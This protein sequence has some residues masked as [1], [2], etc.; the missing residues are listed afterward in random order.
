MR[1]RQERR[2]HM[3]SHMAR[4]SEL[5]CDAAPVLGAD[6]HQAVNVLDDLHCGLPSATPPATCNG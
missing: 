6:A 2:Q 5:R 3:L 4:L 1:R